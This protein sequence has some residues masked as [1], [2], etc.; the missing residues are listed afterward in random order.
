MFPGGIQDYTVNEDAQISALLRFADSR[1]QA[2]QQQAQPIEG[3][4]DEDGLYQLYEGDLYWEDLYNEQQS[5]T[6]AAEDQQAQQQEEEQQSEEEYVDDLY[7]EGLYE[8]HSMEAEQ[9]AQEQQLMAAALSDQEEPLP[10]LLSFADLDAW[11][12][13]QPSAVD[14]AIQQ[15]DSVRVG[16]LPDLLI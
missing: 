6:E 13:T 9:Q 12:S 5:T 2:E 16:S 1:Q 4:F 14:V 8:Q 3:Q 11:L 7:W 15:L 10:D